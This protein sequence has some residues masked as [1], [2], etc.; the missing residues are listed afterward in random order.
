MSVNDVMD[1]ISKGKHKDLST[2]SAKELGNIMDTLNK[3]P[4]ESASEKLSGND[5][6]TDSSYKMDLSSGE[7]KSDTYNYTISNDESVDTKKKKKKK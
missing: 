6:K 3:F 2:E 7:K 4:K 5:E 1:F